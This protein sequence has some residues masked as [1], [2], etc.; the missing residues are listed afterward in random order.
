MSNKNSKTTTTTPKASLLPASSENINVFYILRR[1]EKDHNNDSINTPKYFSEVRELLLTKQIISSSNKPEDILADSQVRS[2]MER[3]IALKLPQEPN[4]EFA[5]I[6]EHKLYFD[7]ET[8]NDWDLVFDEFDITDDEDQAEL[9]KKRSLIKRRVRDRT[10]KFVRNLFAETPAAAEAAPLPAE[11][12]K[13]SKRKISAAQSHKNKKQFVQILKHL[14]SGIGFISFNVKAAADP[15]NDDD[16]HQVEFTTGKDW[17]DLTDEMFGLQQNQKKQKKDNA[18]KQ[19]NANAAE[20][21]EDSAAA[22]QHDAEQDAEQDAENDENPTAEKHDIGDEEAKHEQN[23][24][25]DE[26]EAEADVAEL[27]DADN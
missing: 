2:A 25:S 24:V 11:T 17:I 19:D 12:K 15:N 4:F 7:C 6:S 9:Q 23:D 8:Q 5:A 20:N 1:F 3:C 26:E 13:S 10:R 22:E 16:D 18:M 27:I 21:D 14:Q